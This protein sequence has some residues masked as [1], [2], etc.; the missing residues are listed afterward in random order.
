MGVGNS[1]KINKADAH[2]LLR[3][4]VADWFGIGPATAEVLMTLYAASGPLEPHALA[5]M[6]RLGLSAKSIK[7]HITYI[8]QALEKGS[9]LGGQAY[10]L[11]EI[12]RADYR[13]ALQVM[14]DALAGA[15]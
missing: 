6:C 12:G 5:P 14:K 2:I 11:T 13:N 9:V 3:R 8:K 1:I 10:Y 7:C 15:Q 4:A